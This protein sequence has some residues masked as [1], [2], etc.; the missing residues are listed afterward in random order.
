MARIRNLISD[1]KNERGVYKENMPD[2]EVPFSD[3]E[4]E[5]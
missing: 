4:V 2:I 3:I 1:N 5:K